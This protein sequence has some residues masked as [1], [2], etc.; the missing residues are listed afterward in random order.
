MRRD[1]IGL[2]LAAA[3]SAAPAS[4][5]AA[6]RIGRA[7]PPTDEF[8]PVTASVLSPNNADWFCSRSPTAYGLLP[9]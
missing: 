6:N 5:A 7:A 9:T 3:I 8:T 1:I 2:I 4:F